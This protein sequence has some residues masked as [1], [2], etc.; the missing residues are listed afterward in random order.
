MLTAKQRDTLDQVAW[1]Q[2]H[3]GSLLTNR[4]NRRR[5]VMRLVDLGFARSVGLVEQCDGDGFVIEGR[6]M[7][8]GFALTDRGL[9][10]VSPRWRRKLA[11]E[12]EAT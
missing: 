4:L 5:D 11:G 8:E 7:R 1:G 6:T 10:A 2:Y 3:F 9:R 12:Q